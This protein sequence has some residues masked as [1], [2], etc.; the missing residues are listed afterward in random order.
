MA[1]E[2]QI[3]ATS[4]ATI[5]ALI[6]NI[7][8]K[9]YNGSDF[10]TWSD[11]NVDIYDIQLTEQGTSGFYIGDFPAISSGLYSLVA[12]NQSGVSPSPGDLLTGAGNISWNGSEVIGGS[13]LVEYEINVGHSEREINIEEGLSTSLDRQAI[14]ITKGNQSTSSSGGVQ[15]TTG[16]DKV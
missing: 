9:I 1:G 8:G 6:Y 14:T 11:A 12:K 4:G 7:N 16:V 15:I 10:E 3:Q 2:I 5:Y 13:G